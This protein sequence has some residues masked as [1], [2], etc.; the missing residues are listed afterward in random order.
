MYNEMAGKSYTIP[1][2]LDKALT[3]VWEPDLIKNLDDNK[4]WIRLPFSPNVVDFTSV[5]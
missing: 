5:N 2:K 3:F 4:V 1:K